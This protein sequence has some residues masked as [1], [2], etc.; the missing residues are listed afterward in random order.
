MK[1]IPVVDCDVH[2]HENPQ[3][4]AEHCEE[5]WRRTLT[6]IDAST[7]RSLDLPGLSLGGQSGPDPTWPVNRNRRFVVGSPDRLKEE[8]GNMGIER[9]VLFPDH[10]L[11]LAIFPNKDYAM[12]VARAYNRWLVE[13]W[14]GTEGLFGAL[15]VAPQDPEG[16]AEE[17]GRFKRDKNIVCVYLPAA[18]V[19][20]LYGDSKYDA[21]Y[22]AAEKNGLPVVL[23]S[24]G[25]VHPNFP[26][27]LEQFPNEFGRHVFAHPTAMSAN[28]V[29]MMSTGVPVRYPK[30]KICF[31]E[32]AISWVPWVMMRMDKEY[33]EYRY[34]V[35][36]LT[37][38][39]SHYVRNFY[40]GT[41]PIEEPEKAS[42]YLK[43]LELIG[44]YRRVCFSSDWPHHDFDHPS[45]LLSY[46]LPE[47]VKRMIAAENA[48]E[49]FGL[50]KS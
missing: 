11:K 10:L 33:Q 22:E 44:D 25:I 7:E 3:E 15:C 21:V 30:L 40:Y 27:Q 46:P 5:P 17:I 9:A 29:H 43:L 6:E 47:D 50:P 19:H 35:P 48:V 16:S 49:L 45:K 36:F 1:D 8:L 42:D 31:M 28:L 20:P 12:A 23:H 38:R 37:E 24:V 18:G 32:A 39:P 13:K 26:F 4:L 14:T 34:Q 41:Q 2:V